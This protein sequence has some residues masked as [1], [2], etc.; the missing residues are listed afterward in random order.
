M[1]GSRW[2]GFREY[3]R[4]EEALGLVLSLSKTLGSEEV[5][6]EEACGRVLFEDLFSPLDFPPFDRSAVD[7]YAVRAEDTFNASETSPRTLEVVKGRVRPGK[8][9][10]IMTGRPLPPGANAVVMVEHTRR[11]GKE[12]EILLPVT[13]GK[14][15]STRGEDVRKGER[16]LEKG[17]RLGPQEVGMLACL[18]FRRVRVFRRPRVS[19]LSTGSELREPGQKLGR[20]EIPDINSY[21]LACAV[22][23]CGALPIL[24]GRCPDEKKELGRKLEEGT[25]RA[26]VM[27]VSGG[28]SVGKEDLVPELVRERGELLFHGI[29]LRPGGPTA[30]GRIGGKP[31]FCLPGF[32]AACLLSYTFLVRPFLRFLQGLPPERGL[33]K[34][35]ARVSRRVASSLG[36]V[37]VV[38]VKL[39][40]ERGLWAEPLRVTGAGI[41]SSLT[42]SDGFFLIPEDVEVV[43]RGERV[44]VELWDF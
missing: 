22:R 21:S 23:S 12:V 10:E 32:P 11:R 35:E 9:A 42:G 40:E 1:R 25:K 19:I 6:L 4:V 17:R 18:G 34:V 44:E 31:I 28:T 41:L 8:A 33:R 14:N 20:G 30:F 5:P 3:V 16:V 43:E 29:N 2:R 27:L 39:K 15:V 37:D 24:L 13:P 38:R 7:G 36:R 26:E